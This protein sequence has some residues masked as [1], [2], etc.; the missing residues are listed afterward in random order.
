MTSTEPSN[1]ERCS[2]LEDRLLRM[3]QTAFD[4]LQKLSDAH[5]SMRHQW[6]EVLNQNNQL[7]QEIHRL[8]MQLQ[9]A[10]KTISDLELQITAWQDKQGITI[11]RLEQI[12]DTLK[13]IP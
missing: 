8:Q 12:Q 10:D 2:E 3:S 1:C 7:E 13:Q 6:Q 9:E 11:S 5:E 4:N